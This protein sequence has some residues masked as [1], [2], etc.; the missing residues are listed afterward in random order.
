MK[1]LEIISLTDIIVEVNTGGISRGY[2]RT[3]YPSKWILEV[4]R[5]MNIP[6]ILNSDSHHPDYI[7][8]YYDEAIALLKSIGINKQRILYRNEWCDVAL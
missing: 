7:D 6:I 2:V 5:D 3:P 4:C 8:F 1:T